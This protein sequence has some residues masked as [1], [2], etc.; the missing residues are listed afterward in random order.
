MSCVLNDAMAWEKIDEN[1]FS[2]PDISSTG[3]FHIPGF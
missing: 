3:I 2:A 1:P